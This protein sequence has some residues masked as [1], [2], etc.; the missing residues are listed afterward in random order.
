MRD[1][2]RLIN[3]DERVC[4]DLIADIPG[5]RIGRMDVAGDARHVCLN[6]RWLN[7]QCVRE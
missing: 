2:R 5:L 7:A 1:G 3:L 6:G 4:R